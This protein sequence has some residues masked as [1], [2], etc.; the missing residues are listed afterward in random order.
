M[1]DCAIINLVSLLFKVSS[2]RSTP[3]TPSRGCR[4]IS[5]L[6]T[7]TKMPSIKKSTS[8]LDDGRSYTNMTSFYGKNSGVEVL[9]SAAIEDMTCIKI[10]GDSNSWW[11]TLVSSNVFYL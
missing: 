9:T 5:T 2:I 3:S 7:P 4:S 11:C 6:S 10:P 1:I 8:Y